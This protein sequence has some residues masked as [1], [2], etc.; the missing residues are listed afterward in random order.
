[1]FIFKNRYGEIR[2][3]WSVAAIVALIIVGLGG[4]Q[5]LIPENINDENIILQ[6]AIT[7]LFSLI[8]IGGGI[9]LFKLFYKRNL[10]HMGLIF[11]KCGIE[12]LHGIIIGT[13]S[14]IFIFVILFFTGQIE[15][16]EIDKSK[17]FT[18]V[19]IIEFI[20]ACLAAF[21]EEF[22]ARGY[23][24]T[25]LKTTRNKFIIF[26]TSAILFSL[27]HLGNPGVT[28]LSFANTVLAGLLFAYMFV[29]SGKLWLP[30]GFHIAWN[31]FQGDIFGMNVSG[32]VQSAVFSIKIG[33]N[34]LLTG[35]SYGP[36]GGILVTIVLLLVFL[37]V[38]FA[39]KKPKQTIWTMDNNLPLT[40]WKKE[41]VY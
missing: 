41:K 5:S 15:V 7:S 6:I 2:S 16:L 26:C 10:K 27:L 36:E 14:M 13:F 35:G 38:Y 32:N 11:D 12:L 30:S 19:I 22:L 4:A 18:V 31:F 33:A 20:S 21:P 8:T 29:K 25:A 24:M 9:L 28:V 39:I 23:M 17:I 3:G 40:R 1:M 34:N 37:Y